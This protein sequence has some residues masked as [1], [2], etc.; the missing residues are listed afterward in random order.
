[1]ERESLLSCLLVPP[2]CPY[3]EPDNSNLCPQSHFLNVH[4]NTTLH[5]SLD[6]ASGLF[7]SGFP[8][9]ILYAPLLSPTRATFSAHTILLYLSSEKNLARSTDH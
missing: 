3:P 9:K 6:L 4:I 2:T 5:L 7:P 1:M 8:T